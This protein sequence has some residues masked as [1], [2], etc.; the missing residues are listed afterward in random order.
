MDVNR[1]E[2]AGRL[3]AIFC[4]LAVLLAAGCAS[5]GRKAG[6]SGGAPL[7]TEPLWVHGDCAAHWGGK[8]GGRLAAV[9]AAA[10]RD[11][12]RSVA[13]AERQARACIEAILAPRV[14]AAV[15][16]FASTKAGKAYFGDPAGDELLTRSAQAITEGLGR[17][18]EVADLFVSAEGS[19]HVLVSLTRDALEDALERLPLESEDLRSALQDALPGEMR[20]MEK[21]VT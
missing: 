12:K 14:D 10:G 13:Q 19:A 15:R 9:G 18:T 6:D 4:A 8:L 11:S 7:L 2:R 1:I 16:D 21:E 20:E 3:P 17:S 5:S